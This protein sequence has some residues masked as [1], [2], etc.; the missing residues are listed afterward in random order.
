MTKLETTILIDVYEQFKL[1]AK[2]QSNNNK[3]GS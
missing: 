2:K 3:K 1:G